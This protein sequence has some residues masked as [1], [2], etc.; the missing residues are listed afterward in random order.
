MH[1]ILCVDRLGEGGAELFKRLHIQTV[2][3]QTL[4]LLTCAYPCV[5]PP[6]APT[7]VFARDR[8]ICT[9]SIYAEFIGT[10]DRLVEIGNDRRENVEEEFGVLSTGYCTGFTCSNV[11][12]V[13]RQLKKH[14]P[15]LV[16]PLLPFNLFIT[17]YLTNI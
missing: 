6:W 13:S 8:A 10:L 9:G 5:C 17:E 2:L 16:V 12:K 7:H 4:V 1:D 3:G 11:D 15:L 14:Q